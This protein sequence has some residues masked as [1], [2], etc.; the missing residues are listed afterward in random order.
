MNRTGKITETHTNTKV[1]YIRDSKPSGDCRQSGNFYFRRATAFL[2]R[3]TSESARA[4]A[5][6]ATPTRR[7]RPRRRLQD[8]RARRHAR[9]LSPPPARRRPLAAAT[10]PPRLSLAARASHPPTVERPSRRHSAAAAVDADHPR[11][12]HPARPSR[13]RPADRAPPQRGHRLPRAPRVQVRRSSRRLSR[14]SPPQITPLRSR[15]T[16][17]LHRTRSRFS[18]RPANYH[19]VTLARHFVRCRKRA[20]SYAETNVR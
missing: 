10:A 2:V 1:T 9:Q 6:A 20:L 3:E 5:E 15:S 8:S 16:F 17:S 14:R 13:V 4:G 12:D 11:A 18:S 19:R 7:A